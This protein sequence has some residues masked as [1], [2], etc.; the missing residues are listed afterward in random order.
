MECYVMSSS[1]QGGSPRCVWTN[2]EQ[3]HG[4]DIVM[5]KSP[6]N[7]RELSRHLKPDHSTVAQL[8]T[9]FIIRTHHY[10]IFSARPRHSKPGMERYCSHVQTA[11]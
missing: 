1:C 8:C 10:I 5:N 7:Q 11:Y 3:A 2:G 6:F 4:H 9:I